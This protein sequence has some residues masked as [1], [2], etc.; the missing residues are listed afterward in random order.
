MRIRSEAFA[1]VIIKLADADNEISELMNRYLFVGVTKTELK[2]L[3]LSRTLES[4][5]DLMKVL[6]GIY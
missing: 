4:D 1:K 6:T 5:I 3:G 2:K